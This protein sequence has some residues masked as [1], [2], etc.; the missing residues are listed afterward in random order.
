[1]FRTSPAPPFAP[2]LIPPMTSSFCVG[3]DVPTPT[4][5]VEERIPDAPKIKSWLNVLI[6][7]KVWLTPSPAMVVDDPGKVMVVESVPAKVNELLAVRVLPA[8][9]FKV[10]VPLFVMVNLLNVRDEVS[11]ATVSFDV[12]EDVPIPTFPETARPF[13]GMIDPADAYDPIPSAPATESLDD[14]EDVPIP[15]FPP[16]RTFNL[17]LTSSRER[18][19]DVPMPTFPLSKSEELVIEPAELKRAI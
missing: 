1:M 8:A 18:G 9:M 15:M 13:D 11:P 4:F 3:D 7:V 6:P 14:G 12:G 10:L 17:P 16:V 5:P 2:N 19:L